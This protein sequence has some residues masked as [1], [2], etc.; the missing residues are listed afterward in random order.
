MVDAAG[1]PLSDP[2]VLPSRDIGGLGF[3]VRHFFPNPGQGAPVEGFIDLVAEI[4][5]EAWQDNRGV[6][7]H[8][9]SRITAT[10]VH[11]S[12]ST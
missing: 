2:T 12:A 1:P 10:R 7:Q 6:L 9:P 11:A 4:V 3:A 5:Y 8:D